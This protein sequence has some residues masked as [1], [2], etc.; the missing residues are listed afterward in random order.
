[1]AVGLALSSS[2]EHLNPPAASASTPQAFALLQLTLSALSTSSST[3][4]K[5]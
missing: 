2:A 1:M 5:S 3:P 4:R